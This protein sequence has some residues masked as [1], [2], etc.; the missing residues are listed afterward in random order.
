MTDFKNLSR[1]FDRA[2]SKPMFARVEDG[3][4]TGISHNQHVGRDLPLFGDDRPYDLVTEV[5]ETSYIV[6]GDR[7]VRVEK[8]RDK[9]ATELL[10]EISWWWRAMHS[11]G[12]LPSI[13]EAGAVPPREVNDRARAAMA[14]G[15]A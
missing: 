2:N 6:G 9:T 15:S 14:A 11:T 10:R 3:K 8:I 13:D 1:V 5:C 7:V 4:V 12:H